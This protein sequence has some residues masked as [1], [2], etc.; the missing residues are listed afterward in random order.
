MDALTTVD[1]E[2]EQ[3]EILLTA[4]RWIDAFF[5]ICPEDIMPFVPSLLSHVL[6][7]MSHDVDSVR[8]AAI[9]VNASLM[10]YIMSLSEDRQANG[11]VGDKIQLPPSL[12]ELGKEL[13]GAQRRDS[14]LS[15]RLL[16]AVIRDQA[17]EGKAGTQ[18]PTPGED[19]GPSPGRYL[20]WTTRLLSVHSPCN[21]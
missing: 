9:K 17:S 3:T 12:S 18:S 7:R 1:A 10:D 13:T 21:S 16:K 6:P 19:R 11:N 15:S 14:N 20:S 2:E 4:L 8:Q 5:E